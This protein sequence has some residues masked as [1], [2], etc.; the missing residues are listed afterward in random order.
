MALHLFGAL[1]I[2]ASFLF[3]LIVVV[4]DESA[5]ETSRLIKFQKLLP[6]RP[7][8]KHKAKTFSFVYPLSLAENFI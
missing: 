4:A 5:N 3:I 7:L 2:L 6:F 1:N 8:N